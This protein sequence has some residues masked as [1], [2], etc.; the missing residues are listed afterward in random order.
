M[1]F[2][3]S[4]EKL[5][6]GMVY[7]AMLSRLMS[8]QKTED[9]ETSPSDGHISEFSLSWAD[10]AVEEMRLREAEVKPVAATLVAANAMVAGL[11]ETENDILRKR[12]ENMPE[13]MAMGWMFTKPKDSDCHN[14]GGDGYTMDEPKCPACKGTGKEASQPWCPPDAGRDGEEEDK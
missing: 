1:Q 2:R 6:W 11:N 7:S 14:C 9:G 10:D 12:F 4:E 13:A 3:N 8:Q 5:V